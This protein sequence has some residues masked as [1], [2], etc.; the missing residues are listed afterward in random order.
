VV[1]SNEYP[2]LFPP[3]CCGDPPAGVACSGVTGG[4][5]YPLLLGSG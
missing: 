2:K 1:P 3:K 5:T 4:A